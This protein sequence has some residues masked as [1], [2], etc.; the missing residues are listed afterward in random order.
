MPLRTR[1]TSAI[2]V[3]IALVLAVVA[4][5]RGG[6]VALACEA[7]SAPAGHT[8][9]AAGHDMEMMAEHQESR[10][11]GR[12][13]SPERVQEC[14]L[15]AACAPALSVEV[16]DTGVRSMPEASAARGH[17]Q[18]PASVDRSPDPPPPRS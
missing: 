14:A 13:D 11:D 18:A 1:R 17:A 9:A 12:C 5:L 2:R 7:V 6:G 15:M 16:P 8:L 10:D 3:I 4:S